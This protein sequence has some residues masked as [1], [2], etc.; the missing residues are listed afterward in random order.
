MA[1]FSCTGPAD[2]GTFWIDKQFSMLPCPLGLFGCDIIDWFRRFLSCCTSVLN[3]S[4]SF[5]ML[6]E[7][8]S[9]CWDP[10][11]AADAADDFVTNDTTG[12]V[13]FFVL[14]L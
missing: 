11:S 8:G 13:F 3:S 6:G 5:L 4:I 7:S 9:C 2:P 1:H 14:V 12:L 10:P